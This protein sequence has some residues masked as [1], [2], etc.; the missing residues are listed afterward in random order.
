MRRVGG[1]ADAFDQR[2]DAFGGGGFK[3]AAFH[4]VKQ[5]HRHADRHRLTVRH[6]EVGHLLQLVRGPVAEVERA[7]AA[8]FK[9]VAASADVIHMKFGTA[10]NEALQSRG[11]QAGEGIAHGLQL[12]EEGGIA[13]QRDLDGLD[14]AIAPFTL[15]QGVEKG[16][17]VDHRIGDGEGAH[18]VFFA[19][20]IDAILDAYA[21]VALAERGGGETNVADAAMGGGRG[22]ADQIQHCAAA[23]DKHI[24]MAVQTGLIDGFPALLDQAKLVFAGLAARENEGFGREVQGIAV[25][26]GIGLHLVRQG[27]VGQGHPVIDEDQHLG[28]ATVVAEFQHIT[29][30]RVQGRKGVLGEQDAVRVLYLDFAL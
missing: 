28:F 24:G 9:G 20:V 5:V 30:R 23:D 18:P 25:R 26:G 1:E 27:G 8:H 17:V 11:L 6:R 22:E 13:D 16:E 19:H 7:G 15:G 14:D 4:G 12:M 29:H 21:A 3:N 10:L 2:N